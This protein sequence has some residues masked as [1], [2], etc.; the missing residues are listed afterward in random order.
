MEKRLTLEQFIEKAKAVHPDENLDYS[1]VNYINN[2]TKVCIIDH[3]LKPDGSEYGEYW[4]TPSNHLKG[5]GHPAKKGVRT[6]ERCLLSQEEYLR[7]AKEAHQGENLDYSKV[8]YKGMHKKITIISHDLDKNGEEYGE[9]D[10]EAGAFLRGVSHP[11]RGREKTRKAITMT[12]ERFIELAKS[13]HPNGEYSY[14]K[15]QYVNQTTHVIVTCHKKDKNGVEHGDFSCHPGNFIRGRECPKCGKKLS[16]CE[17]EI[18]KYIQELLPDVEVIQR[19]HTML[20]R[21][22]IDVF[23]PELNI[24]IEYNGLRWHQCKTATEANKHLKK[25]EDCKALGIKLLQIFEDE[26]LQHKDLVLSKI[27]HILHCDGDLPRLMGRKCTIKEIDWYMADAF[28]SINHIQGSQQ[29]TIYYGA[30]LE[31]KI[32][33]VMSFR[34]KAK[35]SRCWELTRFASDIRYRAQGVAAKM[36]N[37]FIKEHQPEEIKT[38]ADRRWTPNEENNMYTALGFVFDGYTRPDYKYYNPKIDRYKR[39]HKFN[40][41]KQ[42]LCKKYPDQVDMSM[43]ETEMTKKLGYE[44]IYDCGLIRYVWKKK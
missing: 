14:E 32:V 44:K 23:V 20:G 7:R 35:D 15:V 29:S 17:N 28:L 41:R 13:A 39:F 34:L 12:T 10:V 16:K 38:F 40:F 21:R 37:H 18:G 27:K 24:G 9:F 30:F 22:E 1:K 33:A 4:Q 26:Y 19:D 25:T 6:T 5:Q 3:D 42:I 43:T 36:L 31:D 8:V 11:K 2:K